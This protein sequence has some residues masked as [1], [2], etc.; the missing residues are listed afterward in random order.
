MLFLVLIY[1]FKISLF[2]NAGFSALV[3]FRVFGW[4]KKTTIFV[5]MFKGLEDS[6]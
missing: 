2:F 4:N 6:N 5:S 1:Y 3:H